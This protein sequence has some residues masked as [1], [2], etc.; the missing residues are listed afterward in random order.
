MYS[1]GSAQFGIDAYGFTNC[2]LF[3]SSILYIVSYLKGFTNQSSQINPRPWIRAGRCR[4]ETRVGEG[5]L[6]LKR[7]PQFHEGLLHARGNLDLQILFA[8]S[9]C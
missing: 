1:I 6:A 3:A 7:G 9:E 5:E 4:P 8:I 2:L